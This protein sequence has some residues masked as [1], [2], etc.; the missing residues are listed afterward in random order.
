MLMS[1]FV[2]ANK[3]QNQLVAQQQLRQL[4]IRTGE[5]LLLF[6]KFFY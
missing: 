5:F 1:P 2:A 4:S 6:Q 3:A